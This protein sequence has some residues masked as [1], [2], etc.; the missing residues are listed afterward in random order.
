MNL[1]KDKRYYSRYNVK[2]QGKVASEKGFTFPV[3]ILDIS[4]EGARLKT[5]NLVPINIGDII[6]LVIK[7]KGPIK[8]RAE[9]RWIKSKRPFLEFGVKFIE[10]NMSDREALSSLLSEIAL[11]SLLDHYTR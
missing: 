7:W 5:D 4:A 9:V 11:T 1:L 8:T 2:L 10:M 3:D 6:N